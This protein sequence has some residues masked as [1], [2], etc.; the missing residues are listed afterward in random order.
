MSSNPLKESCFLP[1]GNL[2]SNKV[3]LDKSDNVINAN[4]SDLVKQKLGKM[5][6]DMI[7]D[8]SFVGLGTG[9]TAAC[10]IES[11]AKRCEEDGLTITAVAS[12]NASYELANSFGLDVYKISNMNISKKEDFIDVYVDGADEVDDNF[13][14]IK[15][16]G[17]ALHRE[18]VLALM[19]KKVIIMINKS[20][21]VDSLG[22]VDLPIEVTRFGYNLAKLELNEKGITE[23]NLRKDHKENNYIT[24]NGNY[25]LDVKLPAFLDNP[26][27]MH[28]A[29]KEITGVVETGI[30]YDLVDVLLV[31]DEKGCEK[32]DNCKKS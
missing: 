10:F 21:K 32:I 8:G 11:L 30:F 2:T 4:P 26:K 16:A 22:F 29:L 6:A 15:G 23:T 14:M 28:A 25:I 9:T 17:G 3:E 31:G 12:S 19:A 20:K 18:K 7:E 24:D 27:N 13:N 5:A 1:N